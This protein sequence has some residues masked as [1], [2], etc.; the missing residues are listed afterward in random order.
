MVSSLID[1]FFG[2]NGRVVELNSN[3]KVRQGFGL[4]LH[5]ILMLMKS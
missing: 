4:M 1:V 5:G 2:Q 3:G